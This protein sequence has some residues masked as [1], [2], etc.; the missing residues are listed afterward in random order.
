MKEKRIK[1]KEN[2][3]ARFKKIADD[4]D[5]KHDKLMNKLMDVYERKS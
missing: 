5:E 2:T 1:V 4:N 3:H